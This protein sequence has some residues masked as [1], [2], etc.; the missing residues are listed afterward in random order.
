MAG[1]RAAPSEM[2]V[3]RAWHEGRIPDDL[4]T[5]D[6][7][8]VRIIHRGSWSHGLGPDFRDA[9]IELD[10]RTLV[11]GSIEI[12]LHTGAWR[13]HRHH[14]DRRYNDVVLHVVARHDGGET[15]RHDGAIVP[16]VQLEIP[17]PWFEQDGHA[18]T[19]FSRFGGAVCAAD[20]TAHKPTE[21]R[22]ILWDLGDRR[23]AA[24]AA[25]LEAR[26][27]SSPPAA[28]LYHDLWDGLG[29]SANRQPMQT[30]AERL[31]I[32]DVEEA[33]ASVRADQRRS[34]ALALQ[35]GIAG[36][37]PLSPADAD[38]AGIP[39]SAIVDID[40]LWRQRGAAWHDLA[41]PPTAWTRA[42]VR[43]ANHPAR[44]LAAAAV[45]LHAATAGM[46]ADLLGAVRRRDD[47]AT[48]L[49][50]LTRLDGADTLG[51][52]RAR[53]LAGNVL[54]PFALALAEHTADVELAESASAAW[55]RLPAAE[56]NHVTRRAQ[57][58]VGGEARFPAAGFRGQQGL[59]L[60]D[61]VLCA[62]RRCYECPIAR[63]VL[64]END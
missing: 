41:L 9:M 57:R 44:R 8:A 49:R 17:G 40:R 63:R 18:A 64:S 7:R 16:I 15:R 54:I 38:A 42:R 28:V 11:S 25:R 60:L 26:L 37:L 6:G 12:H 62:P 55:E 32:A 36:F 20:L 39:S 4:Q 50:D 34:L 51:V 3:S 61:Q 48:A 5:V 43:P 13:E 24:K 33:L 27:S 29:Y 22:A 10:G 53:G 14:L 19:D 2:A 31:P 47:L 58:Q 30:V 45:L 56:S 46:A 21:I 23:L 52:D 35:F 1:A 59:I